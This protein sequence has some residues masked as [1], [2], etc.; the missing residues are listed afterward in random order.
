MRRILV[1]LAIILA[2]VLSVAIGVYANEEDRLR[3][4]LLYTWNETYRVGVYD[5]SKLAVGVA[6]YL[7]E[8]KGYDTSVVVNTNH[9]WVRVKKT[10]GTGGYYMV[11][12]TFIPLHYMGTIVT[13]PKYR[14]YDQ[15]YEWYEY[16]NLPE[17]DYND[18]W[19]SYEELRKKYNRTVKQGNEEYERLKQDYNRLVNRYNDLVDRYN[20]L[21]K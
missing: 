13:D 5:C 4:A 6:F 9:A 14:N 3:N 1:T 8:I 17:K 20:R 12:A 10:E 15:A 11:E 2:F 16:M 18:L 19:N 21:R 7:Q